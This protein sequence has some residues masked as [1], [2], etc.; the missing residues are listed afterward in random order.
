MESGKPTE[1]VDIINKET[2]RISN[3][4]RMVIGHTRVLLSV[5]QQESSARGA[6]TSALPGQAPGSAAGARAEKE[7]AEKAARVVGRVRNNIA[8]IRDEIEAHLLERFSDVVELVD[9]GAD[10]S[11]ECRSRIHNCTKAW[12]PMT[13]TRVATGLGSYHMVHGS[14]VLVGSQHGAG[15]SLFHGRTTARMAWSFWRSWACPLS[16]SVSQVRKYR[17]RQDPL[18]QV[19]TTSHQDAVHMT[20]S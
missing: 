13:F 14:Q 5:N 11:C 19:R 15:R 2:E 18:H 10:D 16:T 1:H 12:P 3:R 8:R 7:R 4:A 6:P 20:Q 9:D 17:P